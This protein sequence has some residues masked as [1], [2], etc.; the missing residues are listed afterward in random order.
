M[1]YW[2]DE[3]LFSARQESLP[4]F[5]IFILKYNSLTFIKWHLINFLRFLGKISLFQNSKTTIVCQQNRIITT[6]LNNYQSNQ[7]RST[8]VWLL[9]WLLENICWKETTMIRQKPHTSFDTLHW[10]ICWQKCCVC[11][12]EKVKD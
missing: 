7:K 3:K 9:C 6:M 8:P 10:W 11:K 1:D 5:E 2:F 12:E 4:Y